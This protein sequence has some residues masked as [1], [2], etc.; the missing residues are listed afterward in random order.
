[1]SNFF[2]ISIKILIFWGGVIKWT[3]CEGAKPHCLLFSRQR[4]PVSGCS[5]RC[6]VCDLP[7][8][9]HQSSCFPI[10]YAMCAEESELWGSTTRSAG[11]AFEAHALC[12]LRPGNRWTGPQAHCCRYACPESQKYSLKET[13]AG[14]TLCN[15]YIFLK[16]FWIVLVRLY[17][18]DDH[19][20][21]RDLRCH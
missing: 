4:I 18:H 8:R 7:A 16:S 9:P 21:L 2:F 6:A 17:E 1:M 3:G 15:L 5:E 20:T 13:K 19:V 14:L 10:C 12:S 11:E